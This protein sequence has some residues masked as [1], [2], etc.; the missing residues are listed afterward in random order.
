MYIHRESKNVDLLLAFEENS[1][2]HHHHW[3]STSGYHEYWY[4][5]S[6]Q[7]IQ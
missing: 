5:I 2:Y 4:Q 7:F 3:D 1:R 6:W